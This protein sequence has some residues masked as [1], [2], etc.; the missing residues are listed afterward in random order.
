[1]WLCWP[2][3]VGLALWLIG[4]GWAAGAADAPPPIAIGFYT[5]VFRDVPRKDVEVSLKFWV[6]ELA[7]NVKL[8]F[9]P[10]RFYDS[11]A[12]L[13]RDMKSGEINFLV[14]TSMAVAQNFASDELRSGFSG[15]KAA[16]DHL[17]FVVRRAANIHTLQDLQGKRVALL[18]R[19][20]L[21]EVFLETL[22]MKAWGKPDVTR[23]AG[24]AHEKRS[25]NLVHRLFFNQADMALVNR[26]TFEAAVAMN[27]QVGQQVQVLDHYSFK[28]RSPHIGLFSARVT[29]QDAEAITRSAMTLDSTPRG[30]Q[31]LDIYN[32][33]GIVIT[34]VRDLEPFQELL[35][36]NRAL[37]AAARGAAGRAG[38][39]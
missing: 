10:I 32:A 22:L 38:A 37:K 23:L 35:A 33:G 36:Q 11:M 39:K 21:S 30:R 29:P 28:G 14:G 2:L 4:Y 1:M 25:S 8:A 17:L 15:L 18:E 9:K 3:R 16:P 27:P 31:V 20:E 6:D 34:S 26:N 24:I 7:A 12:E 19:D 5:P 13:K